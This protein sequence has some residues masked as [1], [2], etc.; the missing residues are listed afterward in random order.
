MAAGTSGTARATGAVY[1]WVAL[2]LL[3]ATNILSNIDRTVPA[4][5]YP[6][7]RREIAISDGTFG[8]IMGAGFTFVYCFFSLPVSRLA[9][10]WSRKAVIMS[11]V[12][13]WSVLT[14]LSGA[15]LSGLQF[16]LC[17][18]GVAV[19]EAG[20]LP[21]SQSIISQTFG[22]RRSGLALS[23]LVAGSPLG[24]MLALAL[25]GFLAD[26][27]GWRV[28]LYLFGVVGMFLVMMVALVLRES[29]PEGGSRG[30]RPDKPG[31]RETLLVLCRKKTFWALALGAS[32]Y[33]IF[34]SS[35]AVFTP[36]FL[37]RNFAFSVTRAGVLFGLVFGICGALGIMAGGAVSKFLQERDIR[38]NAWLPAGCLLAAGPLAAAA[39]TTGSVSTSLALLIV[40]KTLGPVS[41]GTNVVVLYRLV[42]P[43][44]W[45][46][47]SAVLLIMMN[48]L[49]ASL[50]PVITGIVSEHFGAGNE[51]YG[52]RLGLLTVCAALPLAGFFF[53]LAARCI[54]G[55]VG[56]QAGP[57]DG[58]NRLAEA[59]AR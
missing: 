48:G 28:T 43:R 30:E 27:V 16:A 57:A 23:I 45:S 36:V 42:P 47:T 6:Q 25:G 5:L 12:G 33:S 44:L 55:E 41:F 54:R 2:A 7:M 18:V 58:S 3:S 52:V 24:T 9:D 10:R 46:M 32:T 51:A 37:V 15:A 17:R 1:P 14:T 26:E 22:A 53:V 11:C 8:L 38:W 29:P 39:Y 50:G 56:A 59:H 34:A 40:V 13:F 31:I 35:M 4:I 20:C 19:G 21:A 49:G